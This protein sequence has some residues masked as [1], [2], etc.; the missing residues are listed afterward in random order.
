MKSRS[1][2]RWESLRTSLWPLPMAMLALTFAVHAGVSAID[3]RLRGAPLLRGWGF[4]SGSGADASNLLTTLFTGIITMSSVVFSITIVA[5][6]LAANQFGSRL[7]RTYVSDDRTKAA[8]GIFTMTA[9][10][11]LLA[12]RSVGEAMAPED[13]PHLVVTVGL[14]LAVTCVLALL[15][16]LHFIARS[17]VADEVIGR[18]AA[19][20]EQSI[21][22]LPP[23]DES[24]PGRSAGNDKVPAAAGFAVALPSRH[25][26]YVQAIEYEQLVSLAAEHDLTVRLDFRAGAFM[27][28]DGRLGTVSPASAVTPPVAD[29]IREAIVIGHVRTPTQDLEF[30]IRQLVDIAL[31]AL[32]PSLNDANTATVV[33][34]RMR[35]ALSRLMGK[36]LPGSVYRDG[37]G[38]VRVVAKQNS[39]AGIIDSALNQIRQSAAGQP[40]VII[41]LLAAIGPIGQHVRT[42]E[43]REAL[44]RHAEMIADAG[45]RGL[46][47]PHDRRDIAD[48]LAAAQAQLREET[49]AERRGSPARAMHETV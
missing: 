3:E 11:C 10:Y 33:I 37:S 49:T 44:L 8:L 12:L 45:L 25:E 14:V 15:F 26:G 39:H 47:E 27:C 20:L 29:A 43:Q 32:S 30:S 28:R 46:A 17:I 48:A 36:A 19:E 2:V 9:V 16:F 13:V 23:L 24:S 5:L 40:D 38:R 41:R 34:D 7:I 31:R 6:S 35:G 18:V 42:P 4:W 22:E 21:A 1:F